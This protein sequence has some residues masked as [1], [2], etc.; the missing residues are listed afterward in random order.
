M[1]EKTVSKKENLFAASRFVLPEHRELYIRMKAEQARYIPPELDEEQR[2]ELSE[3]IWAAFQEKRSVDLTYYDGKLPRRQSGQVI[4]IDQANRRM[5]L[6]ITGGT[7]WIRFADL[8]D[9][10]LG[11]TS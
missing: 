5:K 10:Q 3:R 2:A 11:S 7:I 9:A 6:Q 8:L 4:H 1:R